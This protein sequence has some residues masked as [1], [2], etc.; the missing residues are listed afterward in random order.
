VVATT[1]AGG[2]KAPWLA[3]YTEVLRGAGQ[4]IVVADADR[5]GY[6]RAKTVC[7]ALQQAGLN[8]RVTRAKQGKDAA[9]HLAAGL[10]PD[11]F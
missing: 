5:P 2:A 7:D 11:D 9:E 4:V 1:A 6:A 10:G 3:Q 8:I